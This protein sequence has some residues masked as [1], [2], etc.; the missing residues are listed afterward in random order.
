MHQER[1]RRVIDGIMRVGYE[2]TQFRMLTPFAGCLTAALRAMGDEVDY[3]YIVGVSGMAFRMARK[4]WSDLGNS[5]IMHMAPDPFA[6]IRRA[7]AGLGYSHTLRL[8]EGA[9]LARWDENPVKYWG[10][11]PG[12]LGP[13]VPEQVSPGQAREDICGS[14]DRGRPA[15]ALGIIGPPE[16]CVVAGYDQGGEALIGWSYHQAHVEA[17]E[18]EL[19]P[20]GYFRKVAWEAATPAYMLIGERQERPQ[21]RDF[22]LDTLSWI[23]ELAR[24]PVA[25]DHHAGLAA[26]DEWLLQLGEDFGGLNLNQLQERLLCHSDGL[27]MMAERKRGAAF[28]RKVGAAEPDWAPELTEAAGLYDRVAS[29]GVAI[30]KVLSWN[31][32]GF[33]K[34]GD[35]AVRAVLAGHVREARHLE[36]QAVVL[37]EGLLQRAGGRG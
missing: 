19:E 28:L 31:E 23:V 8:V 13:G 37:L 25:A 9:C 24:T 35:L 2:E 16:C 1:Q 14:I 18:L 17:G 29:F 32:E 7:F 21:G 12:A 20:S 11:Q 3:D 26:Y 33:A 10:W 5:D 34:F 27:M 36:E 22:Y 15:L 4:D 6:S 30:W